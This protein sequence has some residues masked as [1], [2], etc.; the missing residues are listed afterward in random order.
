MGFPTEIEVIYLGC[1][2]PY[3]DNYN[4][5]VST[6]DGSC[7]YDSDFSEVYTFLG[8]MENSSYYLSN[9]SLSWQEA[10]N[11]CFENGGFLT[12]LTSED[13][14][15]LVSNWTSGSVHWIGLFQNIQS[16]NYSEPSGGWEWVTGED[17]EYTNWYQNEPNG[18]ADYAITNYGAT[19]FWDDYGQDEGTWILERDSEIDFPD[20]AISSDSIIQQLY[21]GDSIAQ[22]LTIYNN[23][24]ADLVWDLGFSSFRGS[25]DEFSLPDNFIDYGIYSERRPQST[26]AIDYSDHNL[27]FDHTTTQSQRDEVFNVLV[28][29]NSTISSII[30]QHED[31]SSNYTGTYT[32]EDLEDIDVFFNIRNTD[33]QPEL[34]LEWIYNGGTWVGEWSSNDFPLNNWGVINGS[35]NGG[36]YGLQSIEVVDHN[37]WLAQNIDLDQVTLPCGGIEFQRNIILDDPDAN[38]IMNSYHSG[39][40]EIPFLVEKS[41]GEGTI[42]LFNSDYQDSPNSCGLPEVIK[43]VAYYGA[44]IAGGVN[45][46]SF[47]EESGTIVPGASQDI[48]VELNARDL[49]DAEYET[50]I[51]IHSND[52]DQ[53]IIEIPVGLIVNVPYPEIN[54]FPVS[55]DEILFVGDSTEQQLVIN[56]NGV[57]DLNWSL[58]VFDYG[59]DGTSYVF[60]NCGKEGFDGPSQEDCDNEYEGTLLE[61]MV[62]LNNGLQQWTIPQ[63]GHYNIEIFGASG[64]DGNFS[65][66]SYEGGLG[67]KMEGQF[68]LNVGDI[69]NILVGQ[70]GESYQEGGGGGGTFVVDIDNNPLIIAGGGGGAGGIGNGADGDIET[71]GTS[72]VGGGDGG[73][74]GNGGF[75]NSGNGSAG[76]GFYTDGASGYGNG[77]GIAY[78][79]GGSGGES[80][81]ANYPGASGGF[82]G[83]GAGWCCGGNGGGA[84]GYSGGGTS[85]ENGYLGGGGGGSFN[86][87]ENQ[88]NLAGFNADHGIVMITLDAYPISWASISENSGIVPAGQSDTISLD[89]NALDLETGSYSADIEVYSNDPNQPEVNVPIY[90]SVINSVTITDIDDQSTS[91]DTF[92]YL[93]LSNNYT[94]Y[95]YNYSVSADTSALI[96]FVENDTLKMEPQ[97]NWNGI[98]SISLILTLDNSLSDTTEFIL[99]VLPVNDNPNAYNEVFYVNEDDTLSS[100]LPADDGDLLDGPY[101]TQNLTFTAINDFLHGS[102]ELNNET[103]ELTYIPNANYFGSDSMIFMVMDDGIT[104]SDPDPLLDTAIIVVQ[105]LPVNDIPVLVSFADTSMLEDSVLTLPMIVSDVDNEDISLSVSISDPDFISV[106]IIDTLLSLTPIPNWHDTVIVT[107]V[108]NDN[109]D[110]AVDTDEFQ[111]IVLPV[112]DNP[113]AYGEVFYINEDDTLYS[114]L[115]ADD[116]DLLDSPYDIQNLT[117]IAINDFLNGSFELN[118]E[119]GELTY[120]PNAN[121]FGSDSMIFMVMDDGITGSDPDPLLDTAIIVV[122]ILPVND[123]PVLVSF[124]DTS[125]LEDSVLTLPMI[126]SDVDNEDISLSVSISDPDFI[127]VEIIDTLL[128]LTPVPNWHDTVVVTVVANDNMDRAIDIEEFQMII[129][130]VN[131]PPEFGELNGL[132]G[133]SMNFELPLIAYDVDMDSLMITFNESWDYPEWIGIENNPFRLVGSAP[134][135]GD[136]IFPLLLTDGV[137]TISDTFNLSVQYFH[138]RITTINDIPDDQGG[139]VYVNFLKSFF[140]Q[141]DEPNQFYTVYRL[142]NISDSLIWVEVDTVT[143]TGSEAYTVEVS[144][145]I[146]STVH[147]NGITEF[148]VL[149]FTNIG[150]FHSSPMEGYS[151][152]NLAPEIPSGFTAE[153]VNQGIHL[154][155]EPSN[156]EDFENFNLERSISNEFTE[157]DIIAL[158][159][160]DYIDTNY[161]LN[162]NQYYRLSATDQSGNESEY[163]EVITVMILSTDNDVLPTEFALY[164][165]Y[166]N[167]FNP[168]TTIRYDLPKDSYVIMQIFDIQGRKVNTLI[169]GTKNAGK[170]AVIWDATNEMGES[171][172]VGMYFYIIQAGEYRNTKKMLLLK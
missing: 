131:D 82:G 159:E 7:T 146:D 49:D 10:R 107:I 105:I 113:N 142:D 1:P 58:N 63:S 98:G 70:K 89:L 79:N 132:V 170:N 69:I 136:Y 25:N 168:R 153:I 88:D 135:A 118:N 144:T 59:R 24:E 80:F 42:I 44:A 165:N 5:D 27:N 152:D 128:S 50:E 117:F 127:S 23:G 91:E 141:V 65:N 71:F 75:E 45:W 155:W 53:S 61:G 56:N 120:I 2:D 32:A 72:G 126:V 138:P 29:N 85:S 20:I 14:N 86:S 103:G 3:A 108:A 30:D 35:A 172:S 40:G 143:A 38:V 22:T 87:G 156:A 167:P 17:F 162:E 31:L 66:N 13:E 73:V 4:P 33:E 92:L 169:D 34:I 140:D 39:Y 18:S 163:T 116:G 139:W 36:S 106:E 151:I 11:H 101:D 148:K 28:Y 160:T 83:G 137:V 99:S 77:G 21:M 114:V 115:S 46:I 171:V 41:Y 124:A 62:S 97:P 95:E 122:Q 15:F 8:T 154:F 54:V 109:M 121:Y 78:L 133:V 12:T 166:P 67:T 57:A 60:T 100:V 149:A 43:Q 96:V 102:F 48:L 19:A 55:F 125:M 26:G 47:S 16:D 145:L 157:Y 37:H 119:T 104:G 81:W 110:R 150:T 76:G 134:D 52:P 6:N 74:D 93:P 161:T 94:S 147:G 112:N 64:G 129:L 123:I 84:G 158:T 90:L 68:Y 130:P 111:L 9:N 51:F 164:Q